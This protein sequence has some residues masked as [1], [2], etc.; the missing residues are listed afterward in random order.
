MN[1]YSFAGD[2]H[3][4]ACTFFAQI[5]AHIHF[6]SWLNDRNELSFSL[7]NSSPNPQAHFSN[8]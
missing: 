6:K 8:S 4:L 5:Y 1:H 7:L 2:L 3:C